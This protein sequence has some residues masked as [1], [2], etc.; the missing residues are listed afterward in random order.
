VTQVLVATRGLVWPKGLLLAILVGEG[1][2]LKF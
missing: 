1:L 2:V